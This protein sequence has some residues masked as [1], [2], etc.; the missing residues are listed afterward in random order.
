MISS[1]VPPPLPVAQPETRIKLPPAATVAM[2]LAAGKSFHFMAV[3]YLGPLGLHNSKRFEP[4][5][6]GSLL[7]RAE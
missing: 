5:F 2:N 4:P 3:T 7:D 6:P 1:C